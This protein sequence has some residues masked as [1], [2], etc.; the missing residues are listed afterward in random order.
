M[1]IGKIDP[2]DRRWIAT[3][4]CRLELRLVDST[5]LEKVEQVKISQSRRPWHEEADKRI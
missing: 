2:S 3:R 1:T 5:G 4:V